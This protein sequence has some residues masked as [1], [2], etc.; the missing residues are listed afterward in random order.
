MK[1]DNIWKYYQNE[2][3]ESFS[4]SYTRLKY[5]VDRVKP[6]SKALN[7]GIG[8]GIIENISK[9]KG[10][11][12]YSLDPD[13][14]AIQKLLKGK[15]G[16]GKAKVGYCQN[17]PFNDNEFDYVIVSELLEHLNKE[18]LDKTLKEIHRVLKNKGYIIGTVP[19]KENL[20]ESTVVCPNCNEIFHRWGHVETYDIDSLTS[21]LNFYFNIKEIFPKPFINWNT[22]N[23]KGKIL[24]L[25]KIVLCFFNIHGSN[26]K[27][28]FLAENISK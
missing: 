12:I 24:G 15:Q 5:L 27:I 22:L 7:I 10:I 4:G 3:K 2:Y 28:F 14:K 20:K 23:W 26:E 1:Q 21:V 11:D 6:E 25:I 19:Y 9:N 13:E 8:M 18:D 17:I 16:P